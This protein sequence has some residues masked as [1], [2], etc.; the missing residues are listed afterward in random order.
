MAGI[1]LNKL[2]EKKSPAW[3]REWGCPL[4]KNRTPWCFNICTPVDGRGECGRL[5]PYALVGRT[6][7]AILRYKARQDL[8][9]VV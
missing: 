6:D 3:R 8:R 5:Q 7:G 4:T 9:A 1:V 2:P